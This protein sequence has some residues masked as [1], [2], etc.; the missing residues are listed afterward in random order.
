MKSF[1]LTIMMF[2]L[3]YATQAEPEK[4]SAVF[5]GGCFWCMESDFEKI[6]G[7]DEVISGY[8]GGSAKNPTYE[9][10]SA[11]GTGHFEV[12]KVTYDPAVVSYA[13]L[14]KTYWQLIDPL[15]AAGQFC[16]KGDSYRSAIFYDSPQQQALADASKTIVETDI[17]Q[18]PVATQIKPLDIFYP[19]EDYHQDYYKKSAIKY[20]YYRWRCG[21]DTRL[22]ELWDAADIKAFHTLNS[23]ETDK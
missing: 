18:R 7:V 13:Q 6:K 20:N 17:L 14:V 8:A 1:I 5:A 23:D 16:D 11:G 3:P 10:V 12:V 9:Q 21:R 4:A 22:S 15:D 2:L 19:A